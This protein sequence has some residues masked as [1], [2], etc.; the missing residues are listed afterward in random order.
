MEPARPLALAAILMLAASPAI[1]AE[2]AYVGT[3]GTNA[4]Q[5]K[6]P[7]EQQGAPMVFSAKGYDQHEAHCTFK[8]VKPT[9]GGWN[10]A[11]E[12]S[13][14]GDQQK[15]AFS[16]KVVSGALIM[17]HGRS[18]RKFVRCPSPRR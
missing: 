1:A 15:D 17:G 5:C 10:I 13:V 14:E 9:A 6:I 12:C 7:Q 16:L 11:A 4:A 2:P 8:S 18:T 3:W